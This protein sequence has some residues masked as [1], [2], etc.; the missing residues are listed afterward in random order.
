[1]PD[2]SQNKA[3]SE[4]NQT[5][6]QLGRIAREGAKKAA[7]KA[8]K[9]KAANSAASTISA[10][11]Q[12][13]ISG[14]LASYGVP[15]VIA[16]LVITILPLGIFAI[17]Y[18]S[19]LDEMSLIKD[20]VTKSIYQS[21]NDIISYQDTKRAVSD[22]LNMHYG[23]D[24]TLRDVKV[25]GQTLRYKTEKCD[26]TVY[27]TP[28]RDDIVNTVSA[29]ATAVDGTIDYFS[30]ETV[31]K[32]Q[33]VIMKD[34]QVEGYDLH[35]LPDPTVKENYIVYS[36]KVDE[37]G[38]RI[39][40]TAPGL[41]EFT[42]KYE[43]VGE[44]AD[45]MAKELD[46]INQERALFTFEKDYSNWRNN[47][48][49]AAKLPVTRR[50]CFMYNEETGEF[51]IPAEE[52]ACIISDTPELYES[53]TETVHIDGHK[54]SITMPLY[55]S[56]TSYRQKDLDALSNTIVARGGKCIL[57]GNDADYEGSG[58]CTPEDADYLI[59]TTLWGYYMSAGP[60]FA[61]DGFNANSLGGS[62]GGVMGYSGTAKS[63]FN[64]EIYAGK[65]YG[66]TSPVATM[67][68]QRAIQMRRENKI[69]GST[70][71]PFGGCTLFAQMWFYDHYGFNS[72]G[73]GSSGNG[74]SF[75]QKVINT[76]PDKFERGKSPAPGGLVSLQY[77]QYGH[78]MCVD[79]VNY[80]DGTITISDAN[81]TSSGGVRIMETMTLADFYT[82][83]KAVYVYANPKR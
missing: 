75:A 61:G 45:S 26:I 67:I 60:Y 78:V 69:H 49:K 22:N 53:R 23:C 41:K 73:N 35:K 33:N 62:Y 2:T 81:H 6:E 65:R 48:I 16:L 1:M 37:N 24:G 57:D 56:V 50:G 14:L 71:D 52:T 42:E 79:A 68:W 59:S 47:K 8:V 19:N 30:D 11:V 4:F 18:I 44:E 31:E 66:Y 58:A 21:Y 82:K 46:R 29:Y 27:F 12:Q 15:V 77:G 80:E 54:G 76:Y 38:L 55:Y 20:P 28:G 40:D 51:D 25:D 17:L 74:K 36:D 34:G 64:Y 5:G 32:E 83:W 9:R 10:W 72:S 3:L 70:T 7:K 63:N 39:P 13:A 43:D